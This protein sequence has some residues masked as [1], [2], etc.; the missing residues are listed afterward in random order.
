MGKFYSFLR[1]LSRIFS[2]SEDFWRIFAKHMS[3]WRANLKVFY[4]W[5]CDFSQARD[6]GAR[7][8]GDPKSGEEEEGA[9]LWHIVGSSLISRAC[10]VHM[11]DIVHHGMNKF[12]GAH[13]LMSSLLDCSNTQTGCY[14]VPFLSLGRSSLSVESCIVSCGDD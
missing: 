9:W 7:W 11:L 1:L 10:E 5:H 8:G 4:Y 3:C 12:E 2:C 14:Y 13:S 6:V